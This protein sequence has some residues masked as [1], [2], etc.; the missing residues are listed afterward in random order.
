MLPLVKMIAAGFTGVYEPEASVR[1]RVPADRLR[2]GYFQ[3]WF[4][5]NGAIE[6]GF[7]RDYPTTSRYVLGVPRH[8]WRE[9][10]QNFELRADPEQ[11]GGRDHFRFCVEGTCFSMPR[12]IPRREDRSRSRDDYR[13]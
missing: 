11:P 7:E 9:F 2:L 3:R 13:L 5:D 10:A 8:L 4:C 12:D 6:A 1:H